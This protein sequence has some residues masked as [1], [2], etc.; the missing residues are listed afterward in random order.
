M[1]IPIAPAIELV[2]ICLENISEDKF[3]ALCYSILEST[4]F[5]ATLV[6]K[7]LHYIKESD[8]AIGILSRYLHGSKRTISA[9]SMR[10]TI[11][12]ITKNIREQWYDSIITQNPT[13]TLPWTE[14]E[15]TPCGCTGPIGPTLDQCKSSYMSSWSRDKQLFD[16]EKNRPGIQ[17]ISIVIDGIYQ[18]TAY[19]AGNFDRTA[20]GLFL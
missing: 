17:K 8:L 19:G 3:N 13:S 14:I 18:I 10:E 5:V 6:E 16:V 1:V 15:L 12:E 2:E 11:V 20:S 4:V 7:H 9:N